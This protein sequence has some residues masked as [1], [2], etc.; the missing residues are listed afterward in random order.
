[1]TVKDIIM[2]PDIFINIKYEQVVITFRSQMIDI[3]KL[4]ERFYTEALETDI[5]NETKQITCSF[6]RSD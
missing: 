6:Y 4:I 2:C 5:T 1:M 3:L